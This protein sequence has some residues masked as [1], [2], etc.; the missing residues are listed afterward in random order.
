MFKNNQTVFLLGAGASWHYGYPTGEELVRSVKLKARFASDYFHTVLNQNLSV[1]AARPNFIRRNSPDP[2]PDGVQGFIREWNTA[3]QECNELIERLNAADPLVIDYFL[4]H[5]PHLADMGKLLIAW[6]LLEREAIYNQHGLN[7]NRHNILINPDSV[8]LT[9][10]TNEVRN[11]KRL[12]E[13]DNWYRFVIHRLVSGCEN[14]GDLL[15]SRVKFVTFNYDVSL[16]YHLFRGLSALKLFA[17]DDT[18]SSFFDD[19]VIHVYGKI[20]ENALEQPRP[21]TYGLFRDVNIFPMVQVGA[22]DLWPMAK[23]FFDTVYEASK[24]IR[25]IAPSEKLNPSVE[26]AAR[27]IEEAGC[28]YILGYGFDQNNSTLLR[29]KSSLNL[30]KTRKTVLFTNF[31]DHNL[32]NKTVSQLFFGRVD[33]LRTGSSSILG[34]IPELFYCEKS[35]RNVYDA[36]AYDFDAPEERVLA[37]SQI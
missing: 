29:L 11:L 22:P 31:G 2:V 10:E 4:G 8:G 27:A 20:R 6:V 12:Q 19:R 37:T 21:L 15:Q 36:F 18:I 25:I 30:G 3:I 17:K 28:I 24:G 5:N 23:E 1:I 34:N 16:E 26:L 7:T 32:I 14:S 13:N 33:Q 9:H 35:T